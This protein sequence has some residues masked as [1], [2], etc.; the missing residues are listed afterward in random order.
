MAVAIGTGDTSLRAHRGTAETFRRLAARE[1]KPLTRSLDEVAAREERRAFWE[2][3]R[4]A[5]ERLRADPAAR[6][7]YQDEQRELEGTL[8]DGIDADEGPFWREMWEAEQRGETLAISW[9]PEAA[10]PGEADSAG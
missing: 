8:M 1:G 7:D 5:V 4:Q 10:E 2:E 9:E 3:Y 6:A